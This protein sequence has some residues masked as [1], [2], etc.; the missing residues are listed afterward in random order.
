MTK[1]FTFKL[2]TTGEYEVYEIDAGQILLGRLK[3]LR[4]VATFDNWHDALVC[5]RALLEDAAAEYDG[6]DDDPMSYAEGLEF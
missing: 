5:T 3:I 4:T 6:D 2:N 1:D